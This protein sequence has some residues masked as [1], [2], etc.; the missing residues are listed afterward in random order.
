MTPLLGVD[1][2][3]VKTKCRKK[4]CR[5]GDF[6]LHRHHKGHQYAIVMAFA[7][8]RK[9]EAKYRKFVKRYFEYHPDDI[10][11]VCSS[12]HREIHEIYTEIVYATCCALEKTLE[13]FTWAEAEAL[14]SRLISRCNQWLDTQTPGA[15]PWPSNGH[16]KRKAHEAKEFLRLLDSIPDS[17]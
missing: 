3:K 2:T 12:H 13:D 8:R 14:M 11:H 16:T 1:L 5:T 9:R 10:E 4:R 6:V 15:T 7:R 17:R